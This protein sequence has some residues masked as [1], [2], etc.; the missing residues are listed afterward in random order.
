MKKLLCAL[1]AMLLLTTT[2]AALAEPEE[3][4]L[5]GFYLYERRLTQTEDVCTLQVRLYKSGGIQYCLDELD[6]LLL[7]AEGN[8]IVP[9]TEKMIAPLNPVPAGDQHFL[10]TMIYTLP[11]GVQAEDFKVLNI[12]GE[13]F[14]EPSAEPMDL[15]A[16]HILMHTKDGPAATCWLEKPSTELYHLGYMMVLHVFDVDDVYLGSQTFSWETADCVVPGAQARAKLAN[17]SRL[18]DEVIGYYGI[19]FNEDSEYYFFADVPLTGLLPEDIPAS[20]YTETYCAKSPLQVLASSFEKL[21]DGR[22]RAYC[23]LQNGSCE[24]IDFNAHNVKVYDASGEPGYYFEIE[25]DCELWE[26]E[27]FGFTTMQYTIRGLDQDFV[28]ADISVHGKVLCK[29]SPYTV[30]KLPEENYKV[31]CWDGK[32]HVRATV[33]DELC[34]GQPNESQPFS[35]GLLWY[36]RNPED[37]RMLSCGSVD[38]LAVEMIRNGDWTRYKPI[39]ITG[40]PEGV[41]PDILVFVI[42]RK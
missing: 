29:E 38:D 33:P 30:K 25:F 19:D 34:D 42:D 12:P 28:P 37:M 2:C 24:P 4:P 5:K 27:P 13:L 22:W 14:D 32:W 31:E 6:V 35:A 21:E 7:D 36:A 1:L 11:E 16:G 41:T 15:D 26:L 23:L 40:V 17:L 20:A 3:N 39:E 18:S 9:L 10:V 8:E